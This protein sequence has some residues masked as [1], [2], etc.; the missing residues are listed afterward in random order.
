MMG[1][2]NCYGIEHF[3]PDVKFKMCFNRKKYD[4]FK[5]RIFDKITGA[6]IHVIASNLD[7]IINYIQTF[8]DYKNKGIEEKASKQEILVNNALK[9]IQKLV[10]IK[11]TARNFVNF[12]KEKTK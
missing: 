10:H 7:R 11:R 5:Q 4:I 8:V 6:N 3:N 9:K 12:E 1:N 2:D